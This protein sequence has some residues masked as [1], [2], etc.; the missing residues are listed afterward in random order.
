MDNPE[1]VGCCLGVGAVLLLLLSRTYVGGDP[2][3][4]QVKK[5]GTEMN[6]SKGTVWA[7]IIITIGLVASVMLFRLL[8][9]HCEQQC[10]IQYTPNLDLKH[11]KYFGHKKI[12]DCYE[13][14]QG[15]PVV[16]VPD[17]FDINLNLYEG[18]DDGQ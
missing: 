8:P 2:D 4:K 9:S 11:S 7:S 14:C 3:H 12:M 6:N 16:I 17:G 1:V 15:I 5:R 18:D 13:I 10:D